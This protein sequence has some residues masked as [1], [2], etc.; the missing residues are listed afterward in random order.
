LLALAEGLDRTRFE[1]AVACEESGYLA[2]QIRHLG[3]ALYSVR[4]SNNLS[5]VAFRSC[6]RAMRSFRPRI[7]HTHGGTA[8]LYGRLCAGLIGARCVHTYHGLHYLHFRG[9]IKRYAYKW[10]DHAL[11][12]RSSALL[13]V[14]RSDWDLALRNGLATARIGR[15]IPNGVDVASFDSVWRERERRRGVIGPVNAGS[16]VT[17]TDAAV[18]TISAGGAADSPIIIGT[19]GRLNPE[20]GHMLLIEAAPFVL[21]RCPR[22]RF[23]IVGEG[24]ERRRLEARA[25][26]LGLADR[27]EM[28]GSLYDIPQVLAGMDIFVFPSRWEGMPLAPLEAMAAGLPIVATRV[29]GLTEILE[30]GRDALLVPVGDPP[31]LA[32]ALLRLI[33]DPALARLLAGN[34][35]RKAEDEYDVKKMVRLVAET[36]E[37]VVDGGR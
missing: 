3:L 36:Y 10:C 13:C 16:A 19:V 27:L 30:D 8:G 22:A 24:E 23:R 2:E 26:E 21:R 1:V 11:A 25:A 6:L 4:M 20:K 28:P 31:A 7:V 32:E 33:G 35:R 9:G 12:R 34:G 17:P 29:H 5:P 18:S 15:V 37:S 14:S